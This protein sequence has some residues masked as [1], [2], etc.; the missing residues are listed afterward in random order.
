[1]TKNITV[2]AKADL[3]NKDAKATPELVEAVAAGNGRASKFVYEAYEIVELA[4]RAERR[5]E[6]S[7]LPQADRIGFEA[8]FD[9]AGPSAKAYKF[10]ATGRRV[11]LRR[12]TK[13]WVLVNIDEINVYPAQ[14]ERVTYRAT[15]KQIEE[16]Q[17]RAVA[18]L[19]PIKMAA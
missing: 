1:M 9:H 8:T 13:G 12:A 18:D 19:T 15:P 16:M 7:G 3:L 5:L 4:Q 10:T 17:R 14:G 2:L 11:T 6:H